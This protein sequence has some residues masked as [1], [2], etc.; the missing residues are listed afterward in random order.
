[1]VS[2]SKHYKGASQTAE[3]VVFSAVPAGLDI[4]ALGTRHRDAGLLSNV[5]SE[6]NPAAKSLKN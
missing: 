6:Q 3:R 1:M 4:L 2:G 5:P